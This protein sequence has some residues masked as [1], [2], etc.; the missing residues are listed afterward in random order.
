MKESELKFDR[1]CHAIYSKQLKKK[2]KQCIAQH[3]PESERERAF[4]AF[5]MQFVEIRIRT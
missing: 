4:E 3:Y 2:I 5:Q 1:S